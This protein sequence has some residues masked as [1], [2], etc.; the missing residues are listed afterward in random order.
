MLEDNEL[1]NSGQLQPPLW[2]MGSGSVLVPAT[3]DIVNTT[4][5]CPAHNEAGAPPLN[6]N[7]NFDKT[8]IWDC[9]R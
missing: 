8:E 5:P 1:H 3:A 9:V 7:Q 2:C 6:S 4:L